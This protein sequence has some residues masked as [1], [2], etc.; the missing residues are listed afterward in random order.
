MADAPRDPWWDA[1]R[2]GAR[3]RY[4]RRRATTADDLAN[5]PHLEGYTVYEPEPV[6]TGVLDAEGYVIVRMMAPIGFVELVE[7][8]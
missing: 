4:A 7:R 8:D 5:T 3:P 1:A 6:D 2:R